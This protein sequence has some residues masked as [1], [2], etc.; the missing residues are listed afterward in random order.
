M[1]KQ[2]ENP[3][4]VKKR[5][6]K[7][8]SKVMSEVSSNRKRVKRIESSPNNLLKASAFIKSDSFSSVST[9]KENSQSVN[10]TPLSKEPSQSKS[11]YTLME[12][13][14]IE[15]EV[16]LQNEGDS[17]SSSPSKCSTSD[18]ISNKLFPSNMPAHADSTLIS[19]SKMRA[20][21]AK[22]NKIP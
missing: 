5:N 16:V 22:S 6:Q 7:Q 14:E 20:K 21:C 11:L 17:R 15:M 1:L 13:E 12:E 9:Q 2:V 3:I 19:N 4:P 18:I 8:Q 10:S